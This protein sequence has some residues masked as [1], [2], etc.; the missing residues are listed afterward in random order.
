MQRHGRRAPLRGGALVSAQLAFA[1]CASSPLPLVEELPSVRACFDDGTLRFSNDDQDRALGWYPLLQPAPP[2]R[3]E[4]RGR[5]VRVLSKH[6]G[7]QIR[8]YFLSGGKLRLWLPDAIGDWPEMDAEVC[9]RL[10]CEVAS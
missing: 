3:F 8:G 9:R 1:L 10:G 7:G 4:F 2:P 5:M 6:A